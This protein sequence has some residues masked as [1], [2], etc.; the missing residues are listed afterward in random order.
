MPVWSV[1]HIAVKVSPFK[2][3]EGRLTPRRCLQ[4]EPASALF[5]VLSG[6]LELSRLTAHAK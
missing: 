2:G 5:V 6:K 3:S 1:A 4:G